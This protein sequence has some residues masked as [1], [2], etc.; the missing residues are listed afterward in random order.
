MTQNEEKGEEKEKEDL[1]I[2]KNARVELM[3]MSKLHMM[4]CVI[5]F[6]VSPERLLFDEP[7]ERRNFA[8]RR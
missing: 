1:A 8:R 3:V 4:S 6:L 7:D 5:F 2:L